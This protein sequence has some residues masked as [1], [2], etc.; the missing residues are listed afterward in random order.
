MVSL[1]ALRYIKATGKL[2][3]LLSALVGFFGK[4]CVHTLTQ[5]G[6]GVV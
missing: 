1:I 4:K 6:E 2:N 5:A 3:F